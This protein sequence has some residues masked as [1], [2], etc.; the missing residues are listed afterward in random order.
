MEKYVSRIATLKGYYY[1]HGILPS[2]SQA[3]TLLQYKS[4]SSAQRFYDALLRDQLITKEWT[5]FEPTLLLVW[6][7]LYESIPASFD[8]PAKD[9]VR[10][11]ISF[12]SQIVPKP[13]ST[14]MVRIEWESMTGAGI[15][16]GDIAIVDHSLFPKDGDIV[17]GRVDAQ[18]PTIKY[19]YQDKTG[20]YYLESCGKDVEQYYPQDTLEVIGV[21]IW[22]YKPTHSSIKL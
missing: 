19:Y 11:Q 10:H 1:K 15:Y 9:E 16:P 8:A 21:V 7:N 5:N 14:N 20:K 13:L 4:K 22:I 18:R 6:T 12:M 17:I 2:L 3:A